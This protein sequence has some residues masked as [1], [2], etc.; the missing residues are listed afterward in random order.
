MSTHN[1]VVYS[2]W[3]RLSD[4]EDGWSIVEDSWKQNFL[5]VFVCKRL[6]IVG[7]V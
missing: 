4:I 5:L 3:E 2:E 7:R 1:N 6:H